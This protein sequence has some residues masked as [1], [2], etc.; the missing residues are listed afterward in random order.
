M[1]EPVQESRPRRWAR[2]L[3]AVLLGNAVYFGLSPRLPDALQHK[4]FQI[5]LGLA[6]DFLIC[7]AFY[8]LIG[9]FARLLRS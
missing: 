1:V 9:L 7:A 6:A 8:L 5:D 2:A 4:P 3:A